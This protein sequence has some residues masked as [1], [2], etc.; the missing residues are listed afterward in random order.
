MSI[1]VYKSYP[2]FRSSHAAASGS[3]RDV[4]SY[5]TVHSPM[6]PTSPLLSSLFSSILVFSLALKK[7]IIPKC[8]VLVLPSHTSTVASY[9]SPLFYPLKPP[10]AATGRA[11]TRLLRLGSKSALAPNLL[12]VSEKE[13]RKRHHGQRQERQ[14]GR[15][16]LESELFIHLCTE[17]REHSCKPMS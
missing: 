2:S 7:S 9:T 5:P 17:K 3:S 4:V 16:P 1:I 15:C 12:A 8:Y 14:Q 13:V 11:N 10:P 6:H